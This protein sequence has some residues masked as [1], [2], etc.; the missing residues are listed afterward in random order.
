MLQGAGRATKSRPSEISTCS[1]TRL[2]NQFLHVLESALD[3]WALDVVV[4]HLYLFR[5]RIYG[6]VVLR[7]YVSVSGLCHWFSLGMPDLC[8][9][10]G[11]S[12]FGL[13]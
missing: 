11:G 10:G 4:W 12:H 9:V 5:A 7:C 1:T 8:A 3:K 2:A 6:G 13:G